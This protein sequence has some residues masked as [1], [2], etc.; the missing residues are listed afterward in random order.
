MISSETGCSCRWNIEMKLTVH[1]QP[2][3]KMCERQNSAHLH[4]RCTRLSAEAYG[5]ASHFEMCCYPSAKLDVL[6]PHQRIAHFRVTVPVI[7]SSFFSLP[8]HPLSFLMRQTAFV[9]PLTQ[10][11]ATGTFARNLTHP[12]CTLRSGFLIIGNDNHNDYLGGKGEKIPLHVVLY[13]FE[14][15]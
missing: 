13:I 3:V 8:P 6:K 14:V 15:A 4:S 7:K 12:T 1:A 11:L 5:R 9:S 10:F 2:I